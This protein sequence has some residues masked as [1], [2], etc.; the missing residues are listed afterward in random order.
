MRASSRLDILDR[1]GPSDFFDAVDVKT[2]PGWKPYRTAVLGK[3]PLYLP[4][5]PSQADPSH[6]RY[7]ENLLSRTRRQG[8]LL[9]FPLSHPRL[10]FDSPRQIDYQF[11]NQP[12]QR[13]ILDPRFSFRES[14]IVWSRSASHS[15]SLTPFLDLIQSRVGSDRERSGSQFLQS[16]RLRSLQS[17]SRTKVVTPM[18]AREPEGDS[19]LVCAWRDVWQRLN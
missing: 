16:I 9:S 3:S 13:P 15:P 12:R 11:D 10:T 8:P 18:N 19:S 17:Q 1:D 7:P 14:R 6:C 5:S 2:K 4:L